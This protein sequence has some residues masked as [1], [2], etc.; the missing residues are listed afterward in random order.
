M[1]EQTMADDGPGSFEEYE[2]KYE[3]AAARAR[4]G[5][6]PEWGVRGYKD[7]PT[8]DGVAYSGSLTLKRG[9]RTS[10]V[11]F[12]VNNGNGGSTRIDWADKAAQAE[13]ARIAASLLA[14][15]G[16]QEETLVDCLLDKLGK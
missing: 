9:A 16:E 6:P 4:A 12:F 15:V 8:H 1:E 13:W 10:E 14:G 2:K 3:A 5:L 7:M 11:A